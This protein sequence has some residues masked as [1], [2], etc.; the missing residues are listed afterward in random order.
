[1]DKLILWDCI[2]WHDKNITQQKFDTLNIAQN[3]WYH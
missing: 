2:G 1:M 3:N